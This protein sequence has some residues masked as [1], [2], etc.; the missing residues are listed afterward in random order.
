M[1][2]DGGVIVF[3][4]VN[5]KQIEERYSNLSEKKRGPPPTFLHTTTAAQGGKLS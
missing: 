3:V 2:A 5:A 4:F 1:V